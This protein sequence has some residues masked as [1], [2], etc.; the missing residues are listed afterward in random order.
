MHPMQFR[1]PEKLLGPYM[2]AVSDEAIAMMWGMSLSAFH[3]IRRR[4]ETNVQVAADALLK[5]PGFRAL[6]E[7]L[8]FRQGQKLVALGDSLTDDWQSWFEMLRRLLER[9]RPD[10]QLTCINAALSGNSTAEILSRSPSVLV[11]RPD[12]LFVLAGSNDARYQ[13]RHASETLVDL[14]STERNLAIL[15]HAAR[16]HGDVRVVWI[17]PP[18]VIEAD[19]HACWNRPPLFLMWRNRDVTAIADCMRRRPEVTVDLWETFTPPVQPE[20]F[21]EDGIHLSL[22]GQQR[23]ARTVVT[24]LSG[25]VSP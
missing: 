9:V 4:F 10:D 13:G 21:L 24:A 14:A 19:A 7:G 20:S 25:R 22:S 15:A 12:W 16:Q 11:Q 2:P 18:P 17:T 23:V 8:P 1:H 3:R 6:V 5:E